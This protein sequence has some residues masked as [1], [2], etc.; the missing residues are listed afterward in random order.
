MVD[1]TPLLTWLAYAFGWVG[2]TFLNFKGWI[3]TSVG[4]ALLTGLYNAFVN[5]TGWINRQL[6]KFIDMVLFVWPSTPESYKLGTLVKNFYT[7]IPPSI[8]VGLVNEALSTF[9]I[10]FGAVFVVKLYKLLPFT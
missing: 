9:A 7:S 5:P 10:I 6:I 3:Y 4:L 2:K 1:F 8:G